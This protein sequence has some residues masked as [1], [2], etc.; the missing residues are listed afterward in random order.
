MHDFP[1]HNRLLASLL[2]VPLLHAQL[3]HEVLLPGRVLLTADKPMPYVYFPVNCI[4]SLFRASDDGS[5]VEVAMI[6]NEGMLDIFAVLAG[7][8]A[9][10]HGQ[11]LSA[12]QAYRL[13][14]PVLRDALKAQPDRQQPFLSYARQLLLQL[15]QIALCNRHHRLEQQL[16]RWLLQNLDGFGGSALAVTQEVIAGALGVRREG[17]T[18]AAGRLQA[19]GAIQYSR[20]HIQ[21]LNRAALE[22]QACVCYQVMRSGIAPSSS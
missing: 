19:A 14:T 17:V 13:P 5:A 1:A 21:V 16:C 3:E 2:Q 9:F 4:V 15:A 7:E 12:G 10:C 22:Q 8:K 6:G 20:G 11:S 18:E